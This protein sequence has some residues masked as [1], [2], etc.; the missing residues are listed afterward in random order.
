[1]KIYLDNAATTKVR[2]E[3]LEK[4]IHVLKDEYGNPSSLYN[5][6]RKAK[7]YLD[8]ARDEASK[9]LNC[10]SKEIYFT[11]GGTESDNWAIKG[12]AQKY[13][14]KGN[15]IITSKI[16]HHAILHTCQ[17]LE[18]NGFEVTYL[19]VDKEGKISLEQLEKAIK[20]STILVSIMFANNEV[21]T[22]QP[23]K[24]IGEI[25]KK[26]NIIFHTDA[27]QAVGHV[28]IDV[29]EMNIDLLSLSGHKIK[30]SKGVG[31]LYVRTGIKIEPLIHGGAQERKRRGGTENVPNIA[32][33]G[34]A[35]KLAREN[36]EEDMAYVKKLKDFLVNSILEEIPHTTLNGSKE[37]RLSGNANI[38]FD[39]IEGESILLLLDMKGIYISTGSAC[40]SGSLDPSHVLLSMGKLHEEA[41]GSI[42]FSVDKENT[43]EEIKIV[44]EQLKPIISRLREMSPLFEDYMKNKKGE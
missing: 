9:I 4:M 43:M 36:M 10:E 41:H 39:F 34:V 22:I 42:R 20:P 15:H 38:T 11:S 24:E 6:G 23:I 27:V 33:L 31:A 32:G 16:E 37:N 7:S 13:K 35:L 30:A 8:E 17:Y 44:I 40:A 29:K 28:P 2:E 25:T 12:I 19:D 1:M 5:I 26:N 14:D 3:V 21:G 18:K